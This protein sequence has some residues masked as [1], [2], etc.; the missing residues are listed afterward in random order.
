MI[1]SL[2]GKIQS[3]PV[4]LS[5]KPDYEPE[6]TIPYGADYVDLWDTS[7]PI[8]PHLQPLAAVGPV[9]GEGGYRFCAETTLG[10][11]VV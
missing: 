8:R 5:E 11:P 7:R 6:Q 3:A 2:H 10:K 9:A 1:A 4:D